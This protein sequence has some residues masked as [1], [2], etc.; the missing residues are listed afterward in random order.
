M[1]S[2]TSQWY[3]FYCED[4]TS[5]QSNKRLFDLDPELDGDAEQGENESR[6]CDGISLC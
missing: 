3:G 5:L 6:L 1:I 2:E 4:G